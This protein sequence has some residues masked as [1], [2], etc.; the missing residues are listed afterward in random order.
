MT[1]DQAM[2]VPRLYL[3]YVNGHRGDYTRQASS[4]TQYMHLPLMQVM[5]ELH[6][7]NKDT[8]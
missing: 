4:V 1:I 6:S 5:F 8:T 2:T 3:L 7:W